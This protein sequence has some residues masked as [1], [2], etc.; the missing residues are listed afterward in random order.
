MTLVIPEIGGIRRGAQH[1]SHQSHETQY[2]EDAASGVV[3]GPISHL[4]GCSVTG[5]T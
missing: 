4:Q 5:L 2:R 3:I 1:T